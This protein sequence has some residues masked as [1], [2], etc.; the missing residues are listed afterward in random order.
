[1]LKPA[2]AMILL[3]Y[4]SHNQ[5][6]NTTWCDRC[7]PPRPAFSFE[8]RSC[9]HFCLGWSGTRILLTWA[10]HVIRITGMS[11]CFLAS[12]WS[13][14]SYIHTQDVFWSYS[15]SPPSLFTL[16]TL[17]GSSLQIFY[18]ICLYPSFIYLFIYI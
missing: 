1:L 10:S 6:E 5:V 15:F 11:H 9:K 7:V 2:W 4:L 17:A 18:C 3:F 8:M 16:L 14:H 12:L 13:F